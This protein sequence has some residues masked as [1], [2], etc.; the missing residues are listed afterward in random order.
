[1]QIV[2]YQWYAFGMG[3]VVKFSD[4]VDEWKELFKLDSLSSTLYVY[5]NKKTGSIEVVQIDDEM[6]S[7]RTLIDEPDARFIIEA[8]CLH[9]GIE[10]NRF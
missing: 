5:G 7:I 10:F 9:R 1:V 8:L 4:Y 3:D 6:K 2:A